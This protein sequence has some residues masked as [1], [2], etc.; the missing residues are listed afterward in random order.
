M[1]SFEAIKSAGRIPEKSASA[2]SFFLVRLPPEPP[3]A[4]ERRLPETG[5]CEICGFLAEGPPGQQDRG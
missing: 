1:T 5:L 4:S 2:A 3:F